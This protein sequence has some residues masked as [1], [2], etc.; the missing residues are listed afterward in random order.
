MIKQ[1]PPEK[2]FLDAMTKYGVKDWS[3]PLHYYDYQ[4][5]WRE[6]AMPDETGHWPSKFKHPLH[7]NRYIQED[8]VWIDTISGAKVKEEDKFTNDMKRA[9]YEGNR[10]FE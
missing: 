6:G 3:N 8:D 10:A 4:S 2:A 1:G 7:P 9:I 5:A